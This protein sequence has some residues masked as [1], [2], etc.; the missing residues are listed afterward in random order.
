MDICAEFKEIPSVRS[1]DTV[2]PSQEWNGWT[3]QKQDASATAVVEAS[4]NS[5]M[6]FSQN[7][8]CPV[9]QGPFVPQ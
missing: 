9:F 6:L 2:S 5:L 1:E 8:V 3:T 4:I 7:L